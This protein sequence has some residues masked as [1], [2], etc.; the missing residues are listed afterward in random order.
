LLIDEITRAPYYSRYLEHVAEY[1]RCL[2]EEHGKAEEED[3]TESTKDAKA[4]KS[5]TAKP[6]KPSAHKASKVTKPPKPT[7]TT[8]EPSKKDQIKKCKLFKETSDVPSPVKRS[9]AGKGPARPVVIR[10]PD[11]GRIQLLPDVQGKGKEK[12]NDEQ[13]ALDLLTLQTPK[14]KSSAEQY[15]F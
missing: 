5:K 8:T 6:T 1:Q 11:S 7:P 3:V 13:V 2:D 15:I 10:E 4:T 14:K 12:V 9:K